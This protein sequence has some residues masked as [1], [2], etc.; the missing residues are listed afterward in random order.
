[1][2]RFFAFCILHIDCIWSQL[3]QA[4]NRRNV[5]L[6]RCVLK[7]WLC[8]NCKQSSWISSINRFLT[9]KQSMQA[10]LHATIR[11]SNN[12]K[13]F[14][15]TTIALHASLT[16]TSYVS[17]S[18][19]SSSLSKDSSEF[20]DSSEETWSKRAKETDTE[21]EVNSKTLKSINWLDAD[22]MNDVVNRVLTDRKIAAC[23]EVFERCEVFERKAMIACRVDDEN[24]RT[25]NRDEIWK[26]IS[27]TF[28]TNREDEKN[29]LLAVERREVSMRVSREELIEISKWELIVFVELLSKRWWQNSHDTRSMKSFVNWLHAMSESSSR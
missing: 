28:W 29:E 6:R 26:T 12:S 21:I 27:K 17:R 23:K 5:I 7:T 1:M 10:C 16:A 22:T 2:Q 8:V 19:S 18:S 9:K 20:S 15:L 11:L 4:M 13:F 3:K 24:E 25:R 14:F